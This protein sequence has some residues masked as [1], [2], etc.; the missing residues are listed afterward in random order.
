MNTSEMIQVFQEVQRALESQE[1]MKRTNVLLGS[2]IRGLKEELARRDEKASELR[3]EL[4]RRERTIADN[5]QVIDL[6]RTE[7][8]DLRQKVEERVSQ[9]ARLRTSADAVYKELQRAWGVVAQRDEE[10]ALQRTEIEGLRQELQERATQTEGLNVSLAAIHTELLKKELQ[11]E[12]ARK[13]LDDTY[14]ELRETREALNMAAGERD[15]A[16]MQLSEVQSERSGI[17]EQYAEK[18]AGVE[19]DLEEAHTTLR[20]ARDALAKA[21]NCNPA[22]EFSVIFTVTLNEIEA[23]RTVQEMVC[24]YLGRNPKANTW[25]SLLLAIE[26]LAKTRGIT[27]QRGYTDGFQGAVDQ[28]VTRMN[29]VLSAMGLPTLDRKALEKADGEGADGSR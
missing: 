16:R 10:A 22:A 17:E 25:Y 11:T 24:K 2:E 23:F 21:L 7:I 28:F 29:A 4:G 19:Q 5:Q 18:L 26:D 8:A 12:L 27:Y 20:G 13:A 15:K 9:T 3:E 14:K 6:Q 1:E